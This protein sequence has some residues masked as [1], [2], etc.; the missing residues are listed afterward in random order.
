MDQAVIATFCDLAARLIIEVGEYS[1]GEERTEEDSA[2][3]RRLRTVTTGLI[4][5]LNSV[6]ASPLQ[7]VAYHRG[8]E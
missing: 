3:V 8:P 1:A 5:T 6:A 7:P 2:A 4:A